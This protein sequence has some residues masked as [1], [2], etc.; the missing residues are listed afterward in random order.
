MDL[1][2]TIAFLDEHARGHSLGRCAEFVRKAV[3]A[4]GVHL[5]HHTSAKDYGTSLERVGF[6]A[7][8]GQPT[9]GFRAGD[10]AVIQPI[11]HL[12][13]GHMAM[14]DGH[15]WV[16]DFRQ[17]HGLYPGPSYRIHQP[18]YTVYRFRGGHVAE[19]V[20]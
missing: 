18:A 4:G 20:R 15:I 9:V 17:M 5:V 6:V 1:A 3:E 2:R 19:D 16:S 7:L 14:F 11:P 8:P 12:P 13:H 10:V